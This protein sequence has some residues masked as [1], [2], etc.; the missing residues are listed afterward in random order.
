M[1]YIE[2]YLSTNA[3]IFN[4]DNKQIEVII[5]GSSNPTVIIIT[6]MACS[7]YDW[8]D[9]VDEIS[10]DSSVVTY[11]RPGYGKSSLGSEK[12]TTGK[13]VKELNQLIEEQKISEPIILVG[14]SYGG[15]CAQHF[16]KTYPNKVASLL[17]IDSTSVNLHRLNELVLPV[18]DEKDSDD[19]W[20]EKC[21]KYSCMN[22]NELKKELK[23][24]LT[25]KQNELTEEIKKDILDFTIN[26]NLYK[27]ILSEIENWHEDAHEIKAMGDFP[28]IP[29]KILARD[30]NYSLDL[31]LSEGIPYE[32]AKQLE[33]TWHQLI[34][35]Q[36]RLSN[37]AEIHVVD[38]A[39][40][41][42][43]LDRPD[44]VIKTIRE[45]VRYK[46]LSNH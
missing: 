11:H 41:S 21:K 27:A 8:I 4:I 35:E 3:T 19:A 9:I 13:T 5:K 22:S 2:N 6:G 42:I 7:I 39:S 17:L 31:M 44:F 28:N 24:E 38:N 37:K 25:L 32:E 46:E 33:H 34:K 36:A 29:L 20:I 14:H 12:R 40:H 15:L 30:P 26:P 10:I 16:A 1:K 43:H 18:L 23:P 45:M